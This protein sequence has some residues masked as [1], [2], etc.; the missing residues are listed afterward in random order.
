MKG[1]KKKKLQK[2]INRQKRRE[3][4]V[5]NTE[6]EEQVKNGKM[7]KTK[8]SSVKS[9]SFFKQLQ[10]IAAQE[11]KDKSKRA[12]EEKRPKRSKMNASAKFIL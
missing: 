10:E 4:I 3:S 5:G 9:E 1:E 7:K 12:R 8:D 11:I 2:I 6:V